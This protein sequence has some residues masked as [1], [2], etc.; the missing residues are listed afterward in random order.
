MEGLRKFIKQNKNSV[1]Y[2]INLVGFPLGT[3]NYFSLGRVRCDITCNL[4]DEVGSPW[5]K[6]TYIN[7]NLILNEVINKLYSIPIPNQPKTIINV[8][9]ILGGNRY[10]TI[11]TH[12]E[13]KI[14]ILG[15]DDRIME[16]IIEIITDQC[17]DIS[18]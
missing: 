5:S 13:A 2:A 17:I 18:A 4:E 1:N 10:S 8:G 9:M 6:M 16:K 11:S 12:S 7:A 3:V 15:E 14:E